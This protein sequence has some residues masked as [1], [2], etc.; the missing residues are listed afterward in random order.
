MSDPPG[1]RP[2]ASFDIDMAALVAERGADTPLVRMAA[3]RCPRCGS[4]D[5]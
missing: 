3:V 2:A 1:L 5:T 4:R